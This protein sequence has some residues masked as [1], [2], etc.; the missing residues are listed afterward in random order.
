MRLLFPFYDYEIEVR[1]AT[2]ESLRIHGIKQCG[3]IRYDYE[4]DLRRKS[5][6]QLG[7][8]LRLFCLSERKANRFSLFCATI[9][10]FPLSIHYIFLYSSRRS[11]IQLN[12]CYCVLFLLVL[13]FDVV[14]VIV[15][16]KL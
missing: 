4:R 2:K 5:E 16:L 10:C 3:R 7:F 1:A 13:Y 12:Y 14:I 9:E 15:I 8:A 11:I 6:T